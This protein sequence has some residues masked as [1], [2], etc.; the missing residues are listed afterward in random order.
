M[1]ED[2]NSLRHPRSMGCGKDIA[3]C[4]NPNILELGMEY[5]N[6]HKGRRDIDSL[7]QSKLF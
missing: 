5:N 3:F 6:L 4:L 2:M 7:S 1:V